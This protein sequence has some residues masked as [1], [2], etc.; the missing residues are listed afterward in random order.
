MSQLIG[1]HFEGQLCHA[2]IKNNRIVN[3]WR[4]GIKLTI[5]DKIRVAIIKKIGESGDALSEM[6]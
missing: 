4:E 1:F 3:V 6:R 5:S 2:E